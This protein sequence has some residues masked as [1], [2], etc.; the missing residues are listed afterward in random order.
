[1][2]YLVPLTLTLLL[3]LHRETLHSW[4]HTWL[5]R[6]RSGFCLREIYFNFCKSFSITMYPELVR[7]QALLEV[8]FNSKNILIT[9]VKIPSSTALVLAKSGSL[10]W[11]FTPTTTQ[12]F[13]PVLGRTGRCKLV[14]KLNTQQVRCSNMIC[15]VCGG[16]LHILGCLHFSSEVVF[17]FLG[18]VVFK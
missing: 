6:R 18:E 12:T 4:G 8:Y 16:C 5:S 9:L 15:R 7:R 14:G 3:L 13:I 11:D 1:M 2:L 10:Q 17:I